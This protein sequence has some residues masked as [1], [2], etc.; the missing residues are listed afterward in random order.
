MARGDYAK[1]KE[2]FFRKNKIQ[3]ISLLDVD[4][5][6][7]FTNERGKILSRRITCTSPYWHRELV[8]MIKRARQMGLI[9]PVGEG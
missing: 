7:R 5:M 4:L 8:R 1:R 3:R 9:A 2:C 6:R